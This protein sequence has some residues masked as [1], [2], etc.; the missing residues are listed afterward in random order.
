MIFSNSNETRLNRI[1]GRKRLWISLISPPFLLSSLLYTVHWC[2]N[3]LTFDPDPYRPGQA[4]V[5]PHGVEEVSFFNRDRLRLNGWFINSRNRPASA[6][7]IYFHGKSGNIA[8]S[9]WLAEN[10]ARRGFDV[11]LFDYRGYGK[12][13]GEISDER[14]LYADA[15]SAYEYVVNERGVSPEQVILYGHSLGTAAAVDLASRKRCSALIIESG[16]SSASEMASLMAPWLPSWLHSLAKNRFESARKLADVNCPVLVSHGEP[17]NIV[18]TEQGRILFSAAREPKRLLIFPGADHN[19]SGF[20]GE[21]YFNEVAT[22]ILDS[23]GDGNRSFL[24]PHSE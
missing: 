20:G 12:S 11:L 24:K 4:W 17:D 3:I 2:E 9:G 19:V 1:V 15:D 22:F 8:G 13:E 10:M 14:D 18:P 5:I 7:V 6:T 21:K 16:L 23:L